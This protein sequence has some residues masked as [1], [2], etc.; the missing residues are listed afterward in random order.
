MMFNLLNKGCL[1][2][3]LTNLEL[4]AQVNISIININNALMQQKINKPKTADIK[5]TSNIEE[6]F[7]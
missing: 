1:D 6:L 2:Y 5:E 3:D 7:F 4:S